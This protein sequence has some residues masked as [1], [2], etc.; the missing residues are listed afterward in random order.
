M[1][2]C[3]VI[4][5]GMVSQRSVDGGFSRYLGDTLVGKNVA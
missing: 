5:G 2:A 1:V 3:F 4:N